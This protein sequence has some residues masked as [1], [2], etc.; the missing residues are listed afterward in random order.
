MS[1][2]PRYSNASLR[3]TK[4]RALFGVPFERRK[5][6]STMRGTQ[7]TKLAPRAGNRFQRAQHSSTTAVLR[8]RPVRRFSIR[9]ISTSGQQNHSM[10]R[11]GAKKPNEHDKQ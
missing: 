6:A 7:Q 4:A 9:L 11:G 1:S 5:R 10:L 8:W 2:K 3:E